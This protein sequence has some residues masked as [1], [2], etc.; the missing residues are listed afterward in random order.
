MHASWKPTV[1]VVKEREYSSPNQEDSEDEMNDPA[2]LCRS[3][4]SWLSSTF[5]L[6][7]FRPLSALG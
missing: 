5:G 4:S 3:P 2:I 7:L 6:S 1:V